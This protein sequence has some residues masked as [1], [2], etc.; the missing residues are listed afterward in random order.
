MC[1]GVAYVGIPAQRMIVVLNR[2]V[3][4][5]QFLDICALKCIVLDDELI[6]RLYITLCRLFIGRAQIVDNS[7]KTGY[8]VYKSGKLSTKSY[9]Q[10]AVDNV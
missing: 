1:G 4:W 9:T 8:F 6:N 2:G 5:W 10:K 3:F 7:V